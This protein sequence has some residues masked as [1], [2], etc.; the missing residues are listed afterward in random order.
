VRGRCKD[1]GEREEVKE[2]AMS[3]WTAEGKGEE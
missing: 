1:G 2:D 3:L